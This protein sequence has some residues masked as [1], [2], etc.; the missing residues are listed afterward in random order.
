MTA[1]KGNNRTGVPGSNLFAT[2]EQASTLDYL[3]AN[4]NCR[5]TPATLFFPEKNSPMQETMAAKSVCA[6]CL[7][8][9]ECLEWA[10]EHNE[11]GV[12]GGM[13]HK[14]RK[15]L[16]RKRAHDAMYQD[17]ID[18]ARSIEDEATVDVGPRRTGGSLVGTSYR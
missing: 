2:P 13:S 10:I 9:S 18:H 5:S 16:A 1:L 4:G 12:W 3:K 11:A 14:D 17:Q 7:V 6:G 15:K 8:K